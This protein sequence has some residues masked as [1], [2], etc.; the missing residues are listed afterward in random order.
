M[1]AIEPKVGTI[2]EK[3]G[4]LREVVAIIPGNRFTSPG[5]TWRRPGNEWRTFTCSLNA[6]SKWVATASAIKA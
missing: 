6:W 1:A 3:D 4:K 5:V 2:F